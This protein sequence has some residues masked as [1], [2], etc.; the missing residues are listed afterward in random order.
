VIATTADPAV[1][2]RPGSLLR[3]RRFARLW[4]AQT[5]SV[6]GD[7]VSVLAVP[8]TAALVLDASATQMGLLTAAVW[9]PHLLLSLHFGAWIDASSRRRRLMIRADIGRAAVLGMIPLAAAAHV[10]SMPILYA[11]VLAVG[12]LSVAFDQCWAS[13]FTLV[14]PSG[15]VADASAWLHGSRA[16]SQVTGPP[17]AGVLVA[18]LRAPFAVLADAASF[19]VSAF[20]LR[21]L[22]VEEPAIE[23]AVGVQMRSRIAEGLRFIAAHELLRPFYITV[24]TVNFFNLMFTSVWV[25]Y[26]SR[27]LGLSARLIGVIL[28]IGAVGALAGAAAAPRAMRRIG[29]GPTF[30]AGVVLFMAGPLLFPLAGFRGLPVLPLLIVA[31]LTTGLGVMLLDVPANTMITLSVPYRMRARASASGR[32]I[33]YGIRPFGALAGGAAGQL[34]GLRTAL[35]VAAIGGLSAIAIGWCSPLRHLHEE[36]PQAE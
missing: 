10:L 34:W 16:A 13:M 8:L 36:P 28:G 32:V 25:L 31:E 2:H 23:R 18:W 4:A 21:G 20:V 11:V 19:L 7:Q 30:I 27:T 35:V 15:R 24:T 29:P 3:D 6:M 5:V 14:A 26:M 1:S 17:V 12:A 22:D 33:N 9:L